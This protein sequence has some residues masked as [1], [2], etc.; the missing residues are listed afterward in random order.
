MRRVPRNPLEWNPWPLTR[1]LTVIIVLAIQAHLAYGWEIPWEV[2]IALPG[3]ILSVFV[4]LFLVSGTLACIYALL[5][6][7]PLATLIFLN[8]W[9]YEGSRW[10]I[11]TLFKLRSGCLLA[12]ASLCLEAAVFVGGFFLLQHF[13]VGF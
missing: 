3:R 12:G 13:F 11:R 7:V 5:W 8:D 4:G 9:T 6:L 2:F 1:L 10:I